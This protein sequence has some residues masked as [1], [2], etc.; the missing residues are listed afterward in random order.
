[1]IFR[2]NVN[3]EFDAN[4]SI[5]QEVSWG[6]I[7][8]MLQHNYLYAFVGEHIVLSVADSGSVVSFQK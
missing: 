4:N 5:F 2:K 7:S 8:I 1:M 3:V 6:K